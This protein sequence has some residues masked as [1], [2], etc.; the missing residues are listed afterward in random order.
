MPKLTEN[1]MN[2]R[3][4]WASYEQWNF[5][6]DDFHH[7]KLFQLIWEMRLCHAICVYLILVQKFKHPLSNI[8][9]WIRPCWPEK[10]CKVPYDIRY[11]NTWTLWGIHVS[12]QIYVFMGCMYNGHAFFRATNGHL[13]D[14]DC[15]TV[16]L[17][18]GVNVRCIPLTENLH[19][20]HFFSDTLYLMH[21]VNGPAN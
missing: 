7:D 12:W 15:M 17:V 8:V 13:R 3:E 4:P 2:I 6:L 9:N 19:K 1:F 20:L 21:L 14:K 5:P 10:K 16:R 11:A 18:K